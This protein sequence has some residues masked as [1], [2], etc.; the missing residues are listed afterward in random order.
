MILNLFDSFIN[1][2]SYAIFDSF[3]VS[4]KIFWFLPITRLLFLSTAEA[5]NS[6]SGSVEFKPERLKFS[7]IM[8][9]CGSKK[10]QAINNGT[11]NIEDPEFRIEGPNAFRVDKRRRKCPN[12]LEPGKSCQVYVAFCPYDTGSFEATLF[13]SGSEQSISVTGRSRRQ[14]R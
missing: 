12:P 6:P 7:V 3:V 10:M 1:A 5:Q 13:F 2:I 8:D 9:R 14:G 4:I 11:S